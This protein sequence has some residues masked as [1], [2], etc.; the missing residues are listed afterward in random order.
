MTSPS[1]PLSWD[2]MITFPERRSQWP[3]IRPSSPKPGV[4]L[5]STT[6]RSNSAC[7]TSLRLLSASVAS[8][9]AVIHFCRTVQS[10]GT[11]LA[12]IVGQIFRERGD[13]LILRANTS[14]STVKASTPSLS[15]A[16]TTGRIPCHSPRFRATPRQIDSRLRSSGLQTCPR[17]N[18]YSRPLRNRARSGGARSCWASNECETVSP[19]VRSAF[20]FLGNERGV[21]Q[22]FPGFGHKRKSL[23]KPATF[24]D[25]VPEAGN[26]SEV[27]LAVHSLTLSINEDL[28]SLSV[29][30][31]KNGF[32]VHLLFRVP[33]PFLL[34][35][36]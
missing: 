2:R 28:R 36:Q 9:K 21:I 3:S 12:G 6:V 25:R 14:A 23:T 30:S 24:F 27:S 19:I 5:N 26:R 10:V 18:L 15:P 8:G 35:F 32:V 4:L 20:A 1:G 31:Q 16:D 13:S 33:R 22:R 7:S 29:G 17:T 11:V 34:S